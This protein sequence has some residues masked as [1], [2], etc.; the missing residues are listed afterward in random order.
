VTSIHWGENWGY[1][2]PPN[3]RSFAHALIDSGAVD[4]IHGHSSHHAKGIEVYKGKLILYGC[5][6]FITDYEGIAGHEEYRPELA[7]AYFVTLE[8]GSGRLVRLEMVPF[9]ARRLRLEIVAPEDTAWLH[10]SLNREGRGL[11]TRTTRSP[12]GGLELRW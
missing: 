8:P 7:I 2:I 11:G 3:H 10:H 1:E 12:A 9:R 4:V 6:D 5:G